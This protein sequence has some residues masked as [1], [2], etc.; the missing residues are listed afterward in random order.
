MRIKEKFNENRSY[1]ERIKLWR[2]SDLL[3]HLEPSGA[4]WGF[5]RVKN[6]KDKM[7]LLSAIRT[8]SLATPRLTWIMYDESNGGD[9]IV[10]KGG[11]SV[12]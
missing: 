3:N 4:R 8:M 1:W 5:S 2:K 11:S 7:Q 12:A 10:L 9:E 6:E